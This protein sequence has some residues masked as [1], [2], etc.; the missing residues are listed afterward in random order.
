MSQFASRTKSSHH[1]AQPWGSVLLAQLPAGAAALTMYSSEFSNDNKTVLLSL[2]APLEPLRITAMQ[3]F[4]RR[5][6]D[7]ALP[8]EMA[9]QHFSSPVILTQ[10]EAESLKGG[11]QYK[12]GVARRLFREALLFGLKQALE[13]PES[14]ELRDECKQYIKASLQV[15]SQHHEHARAQSWEDENVGNISALLIDFAARMKILVQQSR[16]APPTSQS[17]ALASVLDRSRYVL[18]SIVVLFRDIPEFSARREAR[19]REL[20]KV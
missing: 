18:D 1:E 12:E 11:L 8:L 5:V 4:A 10:S 14:S 7:G 17:L 6:C 15:S 13:R 9:W 19:F 2:S 20:T 16:V 3:E